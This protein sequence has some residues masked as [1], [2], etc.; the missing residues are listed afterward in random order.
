MLFLKTFIIL[1]CVVKY[2]ARH[3][4]ARGQLSPHSPPPLIT[5]LDIQ[6][7]AC[8]KLVLTSDKYVLNADSGR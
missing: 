1:T 7:M 3:F 6:Q 2:L 4:C 8:H 5:P